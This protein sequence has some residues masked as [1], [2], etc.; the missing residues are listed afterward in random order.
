[1]IDR[2]STVGFNAS[3]REGNLDILQRQIDE[4][5]ELGVTVTELNSPSLT[6]IS[7]CQLIPERVREV[8]AL[9][10][11][12]TGH[13]FTLHAPIPINLM[14]QEAP[15][16]HFAAAEAALELA[17]ELQ[18]P[19]VVLHPGIVSPILWSARSEDL[20]ARE[21]DA[22]ARLGDRAVRLDV[23]IAYENVRPNA[24][25]HAGTQYSY[26]LD[27]R[28]LARQIAALDHPAV[29]A[30]LDINHAHQS[31]TW[32]GVD[33]ADLCAALAPVT[34]H[35]H[36]S[37]CS[38]QLQPGSVPETPEMSLWFGVGDMHVPAG[39]GALPYE[40]LA[41][42]LATVQPD[43]AI[44]IEIKPI[45][46]K[47]GAVQTLASAQAFAERINRPGIPSPLVSAAD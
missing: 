38:G 6:C 47:Q 19:V 2:I 32:L 11:R 26:G 45:I 22:L 34:N 37:D 35:I 12:Y 15:D 36:F 33:T 41:E 13:R 27:P 17:G 40:M 20:L 46:R 39:W 43:T 3:A 28:S 14:D 31:A 1:M 42:V 29:V 23:K 25:V 8:R 30:C 9:M 24:G 4:M 5:I 10:D 16:L 44:V 21:R 7:A 18:T